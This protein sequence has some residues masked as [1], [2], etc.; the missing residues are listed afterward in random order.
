MR[1]FPSALAALAGLSLLSSGC[2]ESPGVGRAAEPGQARSNAP[3]M[4]SSTTNEDLS[5]KVAILEGLLD[6]KM[7]AKAAAKSIDAAFGELPK[8]EQE[9]RI[10]SLVQALQEAGQASK[11]K[12][13]PK[14]P[15]RDMIIARMYFS[16]RRFVEA[17]TLL[18]KVLDQDP[19]FPGARNLLARCFFFLGNPDRTIAELEYILSDPRQSRDV[20]ERLDAFFLIGAAVVEQ[21]G[22]SQENLEKGRT[23]W[24]SYLREAPESPQR[25]QVEK[26]LEDIRAGLR[27]EGPLAQAAIVKQQAAMAGG[28]NVMGGSASFDGQPSPGGPMGPPG[29]G[30]KPERVKNLPEGATPYQVAV[31]H[32]LDAMD[33]GDLA[34][35]EQKLS[36]ANG[37]KP[38]QA[39]VLVG[40]GRV[41]VQTGRYPE[42]LQTFGEA[43]KL[44]PGYMPAWHYNGMAHMM[45]GDPKQAAASWQ[46]ILDEDPSYAQ[47]FS[48]DKRID[49]ARRMAG[50]R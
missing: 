17:A 22:T 50:G 16:E 48:L 27:G 18:S 33:L 1:M 2:L 45:S 25:E 14:G 5:K 38:R 42:A 36:E 30:K 13:M 9:K 7:D 28:Q 46:R 32:G 40:L 47:Q 20:D 11:G 21:P 35:A 34:G 31:A 39:E 6:G 49:V 23:A 41:Y 44:H 19:R 29:D 10:A 24:E 15:A 12:A 37:L 8:E 3:V 4:G 43:I 26:G